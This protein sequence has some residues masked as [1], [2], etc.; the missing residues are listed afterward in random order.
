MN[1][2]KPSRKPNFHS[3]YPTKKAFDD[4]HQIFQAAAM[5]Q[6]SVGAPATDMAEITRALN[7]GRIPERFS[8]RVLGAELLAGAGSRIVSEHEGR[9]ARLMIT[10][11]RDSHSANGMSAL[12]ERHFRTL[13][14]HLGQIDYVIVHSP[15]QRRSIDESFGAA[16]IPL[17]RAA[18][19]SS[20]V[21]HY[22][23][24]AQDAYVA[25][26]DAAGTSIL[27]E[28][29]LFLRGDDMTIADDV[30]IQT[31]VAAIPSHL[32]FQGGNVLGGRDVTLMG[33]DYIARNVSRFGL[34]SVADVIGAFE[35]LWG[36]KVLPLGGDVADYNSRW[37]QE[38]ILSG[39]GF[40][41]IFH[42]D[43]YVTPTG[44]PGRDGKPIVFLG[45]PAC[46]RDV[47]GRWNDAEVDEGDIYD[48]FFAETERQLSA[49]F[50]VRKL[51]LWLVRSNLGQPDWE[52][53]YYVLTWNNAIVQ[54]DGSTRRV[55]LP[56]YADPQDCALYGVDR[57]VRERL[58]CAAEGA[59]HRIGFEV[60]HMDG[61]EDL[62]YGSG[63]VHCITKT[64][65][66]M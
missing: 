28:G 7:S 37:W 48:G 12:D 56:Y 29:V 60:S 47:V 23:I 3:L 58:Q 55:I 43:M 41:P 11:P 8:T 24:W 51:P 9:I 10:V 52:T 35:R 38:G 44:V 57:G 32:Y 40:Q 17:D 6:Q 15:D 62:A 21:F 49:Y 42:I 19:V 4:A 64:L 25:L 46:A 53:R 2:P 61:L 50:D 66:R 31:D 33:L 27:C 30:A 22:S 16:R 36:T 20:P 59:W 39:T 18:L 45:S 14:Q 63:S 1:I 5:K 54:N 34:E 65:R 26:R 13:L